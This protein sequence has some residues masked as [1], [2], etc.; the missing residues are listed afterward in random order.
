LNAE[1]EVEKY[2]AR[3]VAQ[4]FSKQPG[5]DYN[6]TFSLVAR[7]DTVR[8][9][10]VIAAQN[11]W[12]MHQMDI[13]SAFLNGYLEEEVYVRQPPGYEIDKH[14]DKVYKLKKS[15]YGLKQA[16]IVWYSRIDEYLISVGFI[17]SPSEPTLYTKVNQ[18]GNILIVCLYVD[19]L[20]FTGDLS[21][22]DFKNAMKTKFEMND[23]GLMKYFLGIEVDQS[24][25]GI[26]ICQ[27]NYAN[28]V[29]KRFRM[30]NCKPAA[31]SMTTGI[32][33]SKYDKG[34]YVDP[35]LYK[36]LVGSL[37]YLTE[38]QPDIMFVVSLISRFMET[39]KSTH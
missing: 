21:V 16:S 10:L 15:L 26:F 4:G 35:T 24:D 30:L 18:K 7:I 29:L 11:K 28:E 34:S 37:M 31:T 9:V 12:I 25:D 23:L 22:D 13:K 5:I 27:T 38:T 14:R 1:G 36:R 8:M 17:R 19:D 2:K 33:L 3:L 32:K 6:E 39:P 20:I